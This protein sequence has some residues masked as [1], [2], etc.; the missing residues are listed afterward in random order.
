MLC[1]GL[2]KTIFYGSVCFL[3]GF[4][5]VILLFQPFMIPIVLLAI[6]LKTLFVQRMKQDVQRASSDGDEVSR[7]RDG[8]GQHLYC[9]IL[10]SLSCCVHRTHEVKKLV[11][12]YI[13]LEPDFRK[14]IS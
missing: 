12:E 9:F 11:R 4:C 10:Y 1:Y 5:A 8:D 14:I 13:M 2:L 7:C 6:F 3:Q